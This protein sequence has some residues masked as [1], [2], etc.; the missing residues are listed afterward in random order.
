MKGFCF[1]WD[2]HIRT[3]ICTHF[4]KPPEKKNALWFLAIKKK[5][6]HQ[7]FKRER[8]IYQPWIRWIL[9]VS[10][11][12]KSL[13]LFSVHARTSKTQRIIL[14]ASSTRDWCLSYKW[15]AFFSLISF[16]HLPSPFLPHYLEAVTPQKLIIWVYKGSVSVLWYEKKK[17]RISLMIRLFSIFKLPNGTSIETPWRKT[18]IKK[19]IFTKTG[20]V[21][22]RFSDKST[23]PSLFSYTVLKKMAYNNCHLQYQLPLRIK[24]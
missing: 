16:K 3:C 21:C 8:A 2:A 6:N 15:N 18:R 22:S 12:L 4:Q 14:A 23:F 13:K 11:L 19:E 10:T 5:K 9:P 7:E 20:T 24:I 17:K 1:W